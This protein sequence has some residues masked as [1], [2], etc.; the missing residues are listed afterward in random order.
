[1]KNIFRNFTLLL[2][3]AALVT[4]MGCSA[5]KKAGRVPKENK[6]VSYTAYTGTWPFVVTGTPEGDT[7]G[8]MIIS[9]EGGALKGVISAGGGQ[10]DIENLKIENNVLTGV[11]NYNG[12]SVNMIGTFNGSSYEGKVE[13]QGYAFPMTAAKK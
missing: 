4:L 10:V 3:S 5:S 2:V 11:F 7:K 12:M 8:D 13:A 9:A 1:M 6:S